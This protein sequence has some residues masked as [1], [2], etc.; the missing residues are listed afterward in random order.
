MV[1]DE[2]P[3]DRADHGEDDAEHGQRPERSTDD[4]KDGLAEHVPEREVGRDEQAVPDDQADQ[5]CYCGN[6]RERTRG[7]RHNP[8]TG[9]R[10]RDRDTARATATQAL[11]LAVDALGGPESRQE[12][13][14]RRACDGAEQGELDRP[15]EDAGENQGD[16]RQSAVEVAP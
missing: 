7:N 1:R 15:S 11:G 10:P 6:T 16:E 13:Q 9:R 8:K 2:D 14:H 4:R 12:P 3:A 5:E